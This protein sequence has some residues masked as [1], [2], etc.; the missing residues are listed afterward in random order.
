MTQIASAGDAVLVI[1]QIDDPRT[2]HGIRN[3]DCP[4]H[5]A[6]YTVES[7]YPGGDG[8]PRYLLKGVRS[9]GVDPQGHTVM[10]GWHP[11]SFKVLPQVNVA[12][13]ISKILSTM[14]ATEVAEY[15]R[16][17]YDLEA[18]ALLQRKAKF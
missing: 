3:V 11:S 4:M 17:W 15:E 6:V 1:R 18:K 5:K 8:V 12:G 2:K 14:T 13:V 10:I 9:R 16:D 7:T